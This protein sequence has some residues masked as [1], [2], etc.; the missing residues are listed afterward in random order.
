MTTRRVT[1]IAIFLAIVVAVFVFTVSPAYFGSHF[2]ASDSGLPGEEEAEQFPSTMTPMPPQSD[3][4]GEQSNRKSLA[5]PESSTLICYGSVTGIDTDFP[6]SKLEGAVDL[7]QEDKGQGRIL[8]TIDLRP[9]G[10]FQVSLPLGSSIDVFPPDGY[11]FKDRLPQA[12]FHTPQ[13]M[14]IDLLPCVTVK[15]DVKTWRLGEFELFYSYPDQTSESFTEVP[16]NDEGEFSTKIPTTPDTVVLALFPKDTADKT[17]AGCNRKFYISLK[18]SR[19]WRYI[20]KLSPPLGE[21]YREP[22]RFTTQADKPG[23]LPRTITE[24][25][26]MTSRYYHFQ[27]MGIINGSKILE[28]IPN[29]RGLFDTEGADCIPIKDPA[30]AGLIVTHYW[31]G[32]YIVEKAIEDLKDG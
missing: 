3:R 29:I 4:T 6:I 5:T 17:L 14:Q 12:T 25:T 28:T 7:G 18:D 2:E 30:G 31:W 1:T 22:L 8:T 20:I 26:E 23:F 15:G 16:V 11:M 27:S 21:I 24:S 9:N 19:R 32:H 13:Y 10:L